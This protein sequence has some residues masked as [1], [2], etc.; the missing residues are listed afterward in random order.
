MEAVL[1]LRLPDEQERVLVRLARYAS[2]DGSRCFPGVSALAEECD[3]SERSIQRVLRTLEGDGLIL[4]VAHRAGG[5]GRSTEY[6]LMIQ[7][8]IKG[9]TGVTDS[10]RKGDTHDT[11]LGSERVTPMTPFCAERVTPVTKRVTP[12]T[13]KGDTGVTP[14]GHEEITGTDQSVKDVA[15]ATEH[16]RSALIA[17][18]SLSEPARRVVDDWRRK[19]G[20]PRPPTFNPVQAQ[21][22]EDAISDLGIDRLMESNTWAAANGV[23]DFVKALRAA[24]TKRQRDEAGEVAPVA[25][26]N[27]AP[28]S[29]PK[30]AT[31]SVATT[32]EEE[33]ALEAWA[34]GR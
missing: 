5:R 27:W 10:Q 19:Q 26:R 20:R 16:P 28:Q 23:P 7:A 2:D 24:R 21:H 29:A 14:I 15:A 31:P 17:F 25:A 13:V 3:R 33:A 34:H 11:L 4:P 18:S 1:D 12:V 30:R 9:D 32:A 22:L 8:P 6:R